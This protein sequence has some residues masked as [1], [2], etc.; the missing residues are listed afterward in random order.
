MVVQNKCDALKDE[1]LD[2]KSELLKVTWEKEELMK[3]SIVEVAPINP[4]PINT[5]EI[6]RSMEQLSL[7][8]GEITKLQKE[9]RYLK[10]ENKEYHENNAKLKHRLIGRHAL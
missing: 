5:E 8:D 4:Q 10:K 2:L 3:K 9:K 7:K 6:K 1:V